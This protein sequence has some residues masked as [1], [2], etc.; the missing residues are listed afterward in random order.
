[1]HKL[2]F[3]L[4]FILIFMASLY[5]TD[6]NTSTSESFVKL[7]NNSIKGWARFD[8]GSNTNINDYNFEL[9]LNTELFKDD[10]LKFD[11][12]YYYKDD[13]RAKASKTNYLISSLLNETYI[14]DKVGVYEKVSYFSD[15]LNKVDTELKYGAGV[16]YKT[17]KLSYRFGIQQ[18]DLKM[19]NADMYS[20][21]MIK[22]GV[23]Y[24][25]V[26]FNVIKFRNALDYDIP[27]DFNSRGD[28]DNKISVGYHFNAF[29]GIEL[30]NQYYKKTIS[31]N[32]DTI[33][34][35]K[36]VFNVVVLF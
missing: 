34:D 7:E 2:I 8:N 27:I 33:W 30:R 18:R 11:T 5:A 15:E 6:E 1:M 10:H 29:V 24:D 4:I 17:Q 35:S 21:T 19:R 23:K 12:T 14:T 3:I 9:F 13:E 31:E 32:S 26:F 36:T 28:I 25:D 20:S 22:T 16:F